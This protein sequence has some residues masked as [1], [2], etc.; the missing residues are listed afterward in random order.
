MQI[1][2]W[3]KA[4]A[5]IISVIWF[6]VSSIRKYEFSL[7]ACKISW[8]SLTDVRSCFF[9]LVMTNRE[10]DTQFGWKLSLLVHLY[11]VS[12]HNQFWSH[13]SKQV[14]VYQLE[15]LKMCIPIILEI[16]KGKQDKKNLNSI[17]TTDIS[18]KSHKE[19]SSVKREIGTFRGWAIKLW[20]SFY[21][22]IHKRCQVRWI[23]FMLR[24]YSYG[25]WS[26]K[27]KGRTNR[28]RLILCKW[29]EHIK[30]WDSK[31]RN[32]N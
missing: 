8:E 22:K 25:C 16:S 20:Q 30:N 6:Y 23:S 32:K 1:K 24:N 7:P 19:I 12:S 10:M 31:L 21:R 26:H 17:H 18:W 14:N 13:K 3:C 15:K 9:I 27:L 11:R 29:H 4:S 5:Y 2:W 28:I